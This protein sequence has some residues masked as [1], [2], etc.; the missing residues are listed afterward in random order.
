MSVANTCVDDCPSRICVGNDRL[1]PS[2]SYYMRYGGIIRMTCDPARDPDCYTTT[3]NGKKCYYISIRKYCS[4]GFICD[5]EIGGC[6]SKPFSSTYQFA[7]TDTSN[8]M[9]GET[10][11]LF[12]TVKNSGPTDANNF[13]VSLLVNSLLYSELRFNVASG[14]QGSANLSWT[15]KKDDKTI[16]LYS[17]T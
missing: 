13:L 16:E 7:E 2:E 15:A 3:I 14:Q 17:K 12:F 5:K 8:A 6:A 4:T 9:A 1:R 10:L 11:P